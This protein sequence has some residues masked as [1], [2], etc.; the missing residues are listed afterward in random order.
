MFQY[1]S[2]LPFNITTGTTTIQG[3]AARPIVNGAFISRNTGTG[4]DFLGLSARL[5]RSFRI[6]ESTSLETMIEGFNVLNHVNG[7]SRN[8]VFGTGVFPTN[9]LPTFG[10]TL[11]VSDPRTL[12]LALRLKF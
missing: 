1:Y 5:S 7:V 9:P 4:F 2:T 11:S 8:G 10:Q 12:Q 6:T 3:T